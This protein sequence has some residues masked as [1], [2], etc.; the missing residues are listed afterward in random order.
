MVCGESPLYFLLFPPLL[1]VVVCD[2]E[3]ARDVEAVACD[4]E[5]VACDVCVECM[6]ELLVPPPVLV[7]TIGFAPPVVGPCVVA[8]PV[9]GPCVCM[10]A[11]PVVGP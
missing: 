1:D 11:P 7:V 8:P 10:V 4:V 5:A 9:V 6:T 3:V 2:V